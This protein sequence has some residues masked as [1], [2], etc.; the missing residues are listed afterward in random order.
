MITFTSINTD[1]F[2]YI[3]FLT[4]IARPNIS[5]STSFNK[6]FLYINIIE[7]IISDIFENNDKINALLGCSL[8]PLLN[9]MQK[10][11]GTYGIQLWCTMYFIW[12]MRFCWNK[13]YDKI[14]S[15]SH[16]IPALYKVYMSYK[17][18]SDDLFNVWVYTREASLITSILQK[19]LPSRLLHTYFRST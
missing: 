3:K 14:Q 6:C 10:S 12:N 13:K 18:S 4:L 17:Y 2:A 7:A 11:M 16:N 9:M 1:I 5:L 15:F 8:I 19:A